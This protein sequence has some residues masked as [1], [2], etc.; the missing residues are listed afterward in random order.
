MSPIGIFL[1]IS[2]G[3]EA[4]G[5]ASGLAYLYDRHLTRKAT[6][7]RQPGNKPCPIDKLIARQVGKPITRTDRMWTN[8]A[9]GITAAIR[10][11][12]Q[13]DAFRLAIR[14]VV[15]PNSPFRRRMKKHC[16]AKEVLYATAIDKPGC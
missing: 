13:Y 10:K 9:D 14:A 11:A 7:F 12:V 4:I 2:A 6:F 1:L 5:K 15:V 16:G 8:L 3:M